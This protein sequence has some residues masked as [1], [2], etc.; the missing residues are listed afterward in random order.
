MTKVN[1]LA[2]T[3]ANL[4][5]KPALVVTDSQVFKEVSGIV[6]QDILLTSFSI[7][8]ARFKGD[9]AEMV[10]GTYAIN[11]LADGDK[12]L[13]AEACSHHPVEDD[14]GRVKLP[15]W[16]LDYTKRKLEIKVVAGYDYPDDLSAYKLIIH[17]GGCVYNRQELLSRIEKARQAGVP[18]TNYGLAIAFLH[19]ILEQALKPFERELSP[20][21][22]NG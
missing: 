2:L 1:T 18:I 16:L 8:Y 13:I 21:K 22:R 15:R 5:T 9:L 11:S 4:K 12:I 3:L 10:S 6:A 17:C 14:I 20:I 19:G 7:I